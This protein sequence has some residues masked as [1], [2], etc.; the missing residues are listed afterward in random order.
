VK[1][2]KIDLPTFDGNV[3]QWQPYY[4][5]IEVYVIKNQSLADVQKL[6]YLMRSLKGKQLKLFE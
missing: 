6:E 1:L 3:L 2:P 5:S 4:Q